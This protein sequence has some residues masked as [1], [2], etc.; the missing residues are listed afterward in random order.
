MAV[1][2]HKTRRSITAWIFLVLFLGLWGHWAGPGWN[3]TRLGTVIIPETSDTAI[4]TN[5]PTPR[6]GRYVVTRSDVRIPLRDGTV[7][8]AKLSM[9]QGVTGLVPAVVMIHGTGT[10][11]VSAFDRESADIASA[12]IATLTPEKRTADYTLT[13]RDYLALA[14]DYEDALAFL[15]SVAGIDPHRS[16]IYAVSEGCF[17]APIIASRNPQV[18]H[19]TFV[20]APVLPIRSQGAIAADTYLRNL[21]APRALI[22]AISKLIGQQFGESF[23]YIDF[24]SSQYQRLMK[25][26]VLMLYGTGDMSMPLVQGVDTMRKDLASVGNSQLTVR[27][28]DGANHGLKINDVLQRAPMQDTADW[29]NGLPSTAIALPHIAGAQ[30]TQLYKGQRIASAPKF[31]SGM[32]FVVA[33]GSG[34]AFLAVS[35]ILTVINLLRRRHAKVFR[36]LHRASMAVIAAWVVLLMYIVVVAYYATSY[37]RNDAVIQLGWLAVE[38]VALFAAWTMVSLCL[39]RRHTR[40]KT[41]GSARVAVVF[42][43]VGQIV[44]LI[45]LAYW[46]TYPSL[47]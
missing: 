3:P 6:V 2:A 28:Y 13:R 34:I 40:D 25:M 39:C 10:A 16:G 24:D 31:A 45:M 29:I 14:N 41:S 42:G 47:L 8:D 33:F 38:A 21:G 17:I 43:V 30:P 11:S 27:Y 19:V 4:T 18:A 15:L 46:G 12:G 32:H 37:Q 9:P 35:L 26:P 23:R 44:L 20:S 22:N 1:E 5:A 36:P 7:I